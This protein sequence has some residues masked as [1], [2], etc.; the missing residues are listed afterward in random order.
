MSEL[1]EA[2]DRVRRA[3]GVTGD[4]DVRPLREVVRESGVG[5]YPLVAVGALVLASEVFGFAVVVLGPEI[6]RSLG[7]S[8]SALAGILSA[9]LLAVSVA[10]LPIAAF[11]QAR[12][13]RAVLS[14]AAAFIWALLAL[15]TVF[16]IGPW[17]LAI[18]LVVD[19]FATG[20]V[21]ALHQPL[22][23]DTYPVQGRMRILA[24]YQ[25]SATVGNVIAPMVVAALASWAA[26]T[27]RGTML[28]IAGLTLCAASVALKLRDPGVGRWDTEQARRAAATSD[29][30]SGR[31]DQ[32]PAAPELRFGEVVKR[33]LMIRT[34]RRA[35]AAQAVFG[36]LLVPYTTFLLFFLEERWR[37]GPSA[38]AIFFASTSLAG[39]AAL[40][41]FAPLGERLFRRDPAQLVR[42]ASWV[43]AASVLV[44]VPAALSPFLVPMLLLFALSTALSTV[45]GPA[46]SLAVL[47]IVPA[48]FRPH[49]AALAGIYL[50]GVGGFAGALLLGSLDRRFG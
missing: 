33:L 24:A 40:R 34:I 5:W 45:M 25:A 2:R 15:F 39:V 23:M 30:S 27:W 47:S 12:P 37:F 28:T 32:Q 22:L 18:L 14:V 1:A 43:L 19:G 9:K 31:I 3:L 7:I 8:A 29:S 44:V 11:V 17:G 16:V 50:A 21:R 41:W 4:D 6:S 35:L 49:L 42:T 20:T 38:R 36:L 46:V 26:L 13:R 10:T 48:R